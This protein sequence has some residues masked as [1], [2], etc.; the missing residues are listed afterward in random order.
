MA[1]EIELQP[2]SATKVVVAT[3]VMLSFI[4]FSPATI[5]HFAAGIAVMVTVYFW[6]RNTRGIHE[7]S[8]D[9]LKI[10]YI[11]TVMVVLL[12]GWCGLTILTQPAKQRLPPA[13]VPH[14]IHFNEDAVG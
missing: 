3:S 4:S 10:M 13:P 8:D 11:T 2:S 7:S 1:T 14:N 6:R 9:A 12:I 5:N